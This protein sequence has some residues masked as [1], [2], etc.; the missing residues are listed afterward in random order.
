M[1]TTRSAAGWLVLLCWI[2]G[3]NKK[4]EGP[5][6]LRLKDATRAL[7]KAGFKTDALQSA[8]PAKFSAQKCVQG[9]FD[10]VDTV[11]CEYGSAEA[12]SQGQNAGEDWAAQA[13]TGLVLINGFSVLAVADRGRADPDG[14]RIQKIAKAFGDAR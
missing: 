12:A 2:N 13:T 10:G 3:C 5:S 8:D 9:Q 14:K 7:E 6:Q 1:I 4:P 11:L